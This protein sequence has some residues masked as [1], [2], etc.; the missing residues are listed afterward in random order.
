MGFTIYLFQQT[1]IVLLDIKKVI[2]PVK[3]L[4]YTNVFFPD[5][6][7]ELPGYTNINNHFINLIDNKQLL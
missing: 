7:I 2:S 4:D 6:A 3:Y 1:Q 5:F